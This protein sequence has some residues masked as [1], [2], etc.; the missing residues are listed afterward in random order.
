M[1]EKKDDDRV[2]V[3][4]FAHI[5]QVIPHGVPGTTYM[6]YT[7]NPKH[8]DQSVPLEDALAAA[9][10]EETRVKIRSA[11]RFAELNEEDE[12]ASDNFV[13]QDLVGSYMLIHFRVFTAQD[14]RM[15]AVPI[16]EDDFDTLVDPKPPACDDELWM[17]AAA[18]ASDSGT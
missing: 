1:A 9:P 18:H 4:R 16:S 13:V 15:I 7:P 11:R 6:L 12:I 5:Q 10:D 8:R 2:R 17:Q 3:P 14:T